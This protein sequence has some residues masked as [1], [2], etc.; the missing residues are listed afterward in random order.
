MKRIKAYSNYSGRRFVRVEHEGQITDVLVRS[1][2]DG[3][4]FWSYQDIK[5]M[6]LGGMSLEQ[7]R[8][9]AQARGRE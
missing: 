4:E 2:F 3:C 6:V 9:L 8:E 1:S 5:Q 7:V